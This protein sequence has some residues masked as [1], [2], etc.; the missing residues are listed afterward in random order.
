[1]NL[2]VVVGL[3]VVVVVRVVVVLFTGLVADVFCAGVVGVTLAMFT[4]IVVGIKK[5]YNIGA[6]QPQVNVKSN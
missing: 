4:M 2:P 6:E 3:G 5:I 1:M